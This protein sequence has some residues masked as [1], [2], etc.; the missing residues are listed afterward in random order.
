MKRR[1]IERS[2]AIGLARHVGVVR[3]ARELGV[4]CDLLRKWIAEAGYPK[5]WCG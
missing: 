5:G 3:A 1:A 2:E 4:P